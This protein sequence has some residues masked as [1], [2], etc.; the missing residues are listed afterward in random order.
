M[1]FGFGLSWLPLQVGRLEKSKTKLQQLVKKLRA[2]L[3]AGKF[4]RGKMNRYLSTRG[5]FLLAA[6]RCVANTGSRGIGIILGLDVGDK[7]IRRMEQRFRAASLWSFRCWNRHQHAKQLSSCI[8]G[9]LNIACYSIRSDGT[10]AAIWQRQKLVVTQVTCS[11]TGPVFSS[12]RFNTED[13]C[14]FRN[15]AL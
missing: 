13:L 1:R 11:F 12:E 14:E 7:A 5:G 3:A 6:R 9:G 8:G 2:Q 4:H 15:P 10:N